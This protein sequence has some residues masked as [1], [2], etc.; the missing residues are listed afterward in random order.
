[1]VSGRVFL[2]WMVAGVIGAFFL[3]SG[4]V[5]ELLAEPA[6]S[7]TPSSSLD[8]HLEARA[9]VFSPSRKLDPNGTVVP[10]HM[11]ALEKAS[12]KLP[13]MSLAKD[14]NTK[15]EMFF[16]FLL[17]LVKAENSYLLSIRQRLIFIQDHVRW[18]QPLKPAD[19]KWL[20]LVSENFKIAMDDPAGVDF[21]RD[22]LVRVDVVPENL[23]LVQAAN[24][25][26]WGTSRF[27]REGNNLFGQW[28]FSPNC[29]LVPY[30]R[31]EGE[32]YQV[33]E[34]SSVA[35]SVRSYMHNLNTGKAYKMLRDLRAKN[36]DE[37]QEPDAAEMAAGLISY[38]ERGQD[39]IKEIR[40][41]I[42]HNRHVIA[43]V[44]TRTRI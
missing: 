5:T 33:A 30:N 17:P 22:L 27:A 12:T 15:K 37:S 3:C 43:E 34:F 42:R 35:E 18:G 25:S 2:W 23:V 44:R 41:M 40:A 21:W 20:A 38:S 39:Y 10:K 14:T 1:M 19:H 7:I 8:D 31:P 26:G 6:D 13:D 24:E 36:R 32:A 11:T 29:G 9:V 28:C 16:S 4:P